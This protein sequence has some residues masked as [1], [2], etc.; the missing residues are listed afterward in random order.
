MLYALAVVVM[1]IGM[2]G[3]LV[4]VLPGLLLV[5]IATVGTV[6]VQ[7]TDLA[8]WTV[9]LLLTCLFAAGTAATI[10][11][12]AREGRQGGAPTSTFVLA[13]VGAVVGFFVLPV[14]GIIVGALFGLFVGERRRLGDNREAVAATGRVLR[15]YGIGVLLEALIGVTMIMTWAITILLR[16]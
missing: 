16:A 13:G 6:L 7:G 8:G 15:A 12:P 2:I 5:W 9:A 14:L 1:L 11:L 3:I 10:L 4:P